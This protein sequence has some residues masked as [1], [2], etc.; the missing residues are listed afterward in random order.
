MAREP[1]VRLDRDGVA[2]QRLLA[3]F[4][5]RRQPVAVA[6][7]LQLAVELGDEQ[8]A[9]REDE[10]AERARRLDEAR[11]GDCFA[12]CRRVAEAE[13]PFRAGGLLGRDDRL[14]VFLFVRVRLE[15]LFLFP[16]D[17][18]LGAV[19][20]AVPLPHGLPVRADHVAE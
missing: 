17:L 16:V 6:L 20:V 10:Y 12:R 13:A 14:L 3:R 18:R 7:G 1:G 9:V 2:A 4:D 11:S 8:A 19:A 5:R 15:I